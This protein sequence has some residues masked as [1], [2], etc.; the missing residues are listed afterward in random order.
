MTEQFVN[1]AQ[2]SLTAPMNNTSNPV[3]F[4]VQGASAFPTVGNFRVLIDSEILLVTSVVTDTMTALRAQEGTLIAAHSTSAIV[5]H[6]LTAGSLAQIIADAI[7]AN[8]IL[9]RSM[10]EPYS[11]GTLLTKPVAADPG[12]IVAADVV[13]SNPYHITPT[14]QPDV[15]RG[16]SFTCDQ[17]AFIY[18]EGKTTQL[19]F[20]YTNAFV[21]SYFESFQAFEHITAIHIYGTGIG[22]NFSV[23]VFD[24]FGLP[25]PDLGQS[26]DDIEPYPWTK[27]IDAGYIDD[28]GAPIYSPGSFQPDFG[29]FGTFRVPSYPPNGLRSYG[30]WFTSWRRKAMGA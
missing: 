10:L 29:Q 11:A 30:V 23:G 25:Q 3:T 28:G 6:I 18:I 27:R 26:S 21:S 9:P 12:F 13:T 15:P 19:G 20:D 24:M 22:T 1:M 7:A 16:I 14:I 8:P 17:P 4:T 2:S 5:T